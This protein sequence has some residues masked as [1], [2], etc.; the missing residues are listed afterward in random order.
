MPIM[1]IKTVYEFYVELTDIS[2]K[3]H[4]TFQAESDMELSKFVETIQEMF[5]MDGS[6]LS[7]LLIPVADNQAISEGKTR[8]KKQFYSLVRKDDTRIFSQQTP[9]GSWTE[10]PKRP[11]FNSSFNFDFTSDFN[12]GDYYDDNNDNE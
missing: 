6:H 5:E 10:D 3:I 4:R 9:Y 11:K 1:T 12:F 8:K 7:Q 2:P